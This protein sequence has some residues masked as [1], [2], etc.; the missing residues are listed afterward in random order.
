MLVLAAPR[1][2]RILSGV[3]ARGRPCRARD[4]TGVGG[5]EGRRLH[6][7]TVS[8]AQ[9]SVGVLFVCS[10]F[11]PQWAVLSC[12]SWRCIQRSLLVVLKDHWLA[13]GSAWVSHRAA[14]AL[15]LYSSALSLPL[16]S[17][18][19]LFWGHRRPYRVLGNKLGSTHYIISWPLVQFL[20]FCVSYLP[21]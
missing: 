12:Y 21:F 10:L 13:R 3:G 18:C 7:C 11:L 19:V 17:V 4:H 14:D 8:L 6:P 16:P 15:S 5:M 9:F 1:G 20:K 2:F